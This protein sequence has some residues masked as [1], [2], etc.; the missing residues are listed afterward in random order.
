MG[1]ADW[2]RSREPH[3]PWDHD[4][5][6]RQVLNLLEPPRRPHHPYL[7]ARELPQVEVSLPKDT[8]LATGSRCNLVSTL[9]TVLGAPAPAQS[10]ATAIDVK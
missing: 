3:G 6:Q 5:S 8:K 2:P 4:L 1:E 10:L 7:K 9:Q